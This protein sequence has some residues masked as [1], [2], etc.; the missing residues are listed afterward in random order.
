MAE[1]TGRTTV[2]IVK[3]YLTVTT[4]HVA[5][6]AQMPRGCEFSLIEQQINRPNEESR[7]TNGNRAQVDRGGEEK[8]PGAGGPPTAQRARN[9]DPY[10]QTIGE[11]LPRIIG[12]FGSIVHKKPE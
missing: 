6:P 3:A 1:V 5:L 2:M 4:S 9:G 12:R 7:R 8:E 11:S 10:S